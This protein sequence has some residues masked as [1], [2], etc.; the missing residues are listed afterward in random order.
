M[1][2]KPR[3][4]LKIARTHICTLILGGTAVEMDMYYAKQKSIAMVQLLT[5]KLCSLEHIQI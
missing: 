5:P 4:S 2:V 1:E 3:Y